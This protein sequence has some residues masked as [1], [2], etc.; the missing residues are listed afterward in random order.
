[1]MKD[2]MMQHNDKVVTEILYSPI[3]DTFGYRCIKTD[4]YA[5]DDLYRIS[6]EL[7]CLLSDVY[8]AIGKRRVH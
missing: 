6:A 4:D 8:E 2:L 7:I 5:I 3:D 1:M